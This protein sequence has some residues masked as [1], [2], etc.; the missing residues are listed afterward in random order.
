MR[1]TKSLE[2]QPGVLSTSLL[3]V[4]PYMDVDGMGSGGLVITE[5]DPDRAVQ[6][7]GEIARR[8]WDRRHDLE[9]DTCVPAEAIREGSRSWEAR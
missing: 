8:Y 6:L 4:H 1:Y 2:Q 3:L 7:A 9:P 5:G